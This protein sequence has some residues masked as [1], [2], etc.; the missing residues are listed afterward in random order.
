MPERKY[1]ILDPQINQ[2]A[3]DTCYLNQWNDPIY[4]NYSF[5][6]WYGDIHSVHAFWSMHKTLTK[7]HAC[8]QIYYCPHDLSRILQLK[9]M[10]PSDCISLYWHNWVW[11]LD[12]KDAFVIISM[13]RLILSSLGFVITDQILGRQLWS[14]DHLMIPL[15]FVILVDHCCDR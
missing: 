8:D 14:C 7:C 6:H 9:H 3:L 12:C 10:M 2:R 11:S 15:N 1:T 5:G 13:S 4:Q